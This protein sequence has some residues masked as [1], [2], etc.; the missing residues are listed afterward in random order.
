MTAIGVVET[1]SI[2]LGVLAG[3]AMV[4]TAAVELVA[5]QTACAGK[6]IV[7]VSGDVAAVRAAVIA[8]AEGA[9]ASLVD[10]L[11]IPNVDERVIVAMSGAP[12][13]D[14]AQAVGVI[15]TFSLASTIAAADIA[16]KTAEVEL[17]EVRLGRGMGGKSFLVFTGEVA[18]VTAASRAIEANE[19]S[20]GLIGSSVVIPSPHMDM[21]K[22]L[23]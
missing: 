22:A 13:V 20:R 14:T 8:G 12:A 1:N 4:K 6:Y 7:M 19:D 5:A 9:G 11:V 15:E 17:I 23:L 21:V 10:R 16:V 3:D 18:A 2:P